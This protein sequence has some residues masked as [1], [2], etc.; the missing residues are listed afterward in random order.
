[1]QMVPFSGRMFPEWSVREGRLSYRS[2]IGSGDFVIAK[3]V[4]SEWC[5]G[6]F[7]STQI[8]RRDEVPQ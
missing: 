3:R 4:C 2:L 6:S 7:G 5:Y 8:H 1:M